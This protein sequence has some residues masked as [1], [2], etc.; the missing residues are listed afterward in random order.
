MLS[1]SKD[2]HAARRIRELRIDR[3]MTPEGLSYEIS[4]LSPRYSVSGRTIRRIESTGAIPTV[5][6]M[7]GIAQVFGLQ[8][9]DIWHV[10]LRVAA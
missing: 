7:F 9:S 6:V 1:M 4:K 5:R 8:V 10:D 3:G 2:V